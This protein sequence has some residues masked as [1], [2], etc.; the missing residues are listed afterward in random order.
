MTRY[1]L[2]LIG[3]LLLVAAPAAAQTEVGDKAPEWDADEWY[4]LPGG[5][6]SLK[7]S[8]VAGQIVVLEFWATWCGPCR[9]T[10]PHLVDT[11]DK[12]KS[13]GVVIIGL[14]DETDSKV[15]P[16]IKEMKMNY[17]VGSG[18]E[19]TQKAY[20][21]TAI[22]AAF[23]IGPDGKILWKGHAAM[24]R[25]AIDKALKESPPKTKGILAEK[26]ADVAYSKA[27]KL[28]KDRKYSEA[29]QA[30]EEISKGYKGTKTA[31]EAKGK[32]DQIKSNSRI[33][34]IVRKEEAERISLGWLTI[35]RACVQYGDKADAVR[36]YKRIME[37]YPDTKYTKIAEAELKLLQSNDDGT[38]GKQ[39]DTDKKEAK[40]SGKKDTG[41]KTRRASDED[42][43]EDEAEDDDSDE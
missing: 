22:P 38:G 20:G 6:K 27:N 9:E 17:I 15:K 8:D 31:K 32:L 36:Y 14:S 25:E 35:A 7:P 26:S 34:D 33:M 40:K 19:S 39:A 23:V 4:N 24:V 37:K 2:V 29:M 3:S 30:F 1:M 42:E 21:V 5:M 10:I 16:F 13:R 28:Y 12:Y 11:H 18:A 43:D 41:K